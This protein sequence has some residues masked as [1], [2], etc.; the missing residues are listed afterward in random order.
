MKKKKSYYV[1]SLKRKKIITIIIVI[2][3]SL[4]RPCVFFSLHFLFPFFRYFFPYYFNRLKEI[5]NRQFVY[6][7]E[8]TQR[9][10]EKQ[11]KKKIEMVKL[12]WRVF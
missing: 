9:S 6:F 4:L 11:K 1:T 3:L 5:M 2:L 10:T 8:E 7:G 12:W